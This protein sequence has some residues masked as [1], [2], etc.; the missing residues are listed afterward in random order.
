M[1]T[2]N[3]KKIKDNKKIKK[4]NKT[5][6][7]EIINYNPKLIIKSVICKKFN[8]QKIKINVIRDDILETWTKNGINIIF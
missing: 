8:K 3:K 6:K 2:L 4:D 1:K 5:I 7:K